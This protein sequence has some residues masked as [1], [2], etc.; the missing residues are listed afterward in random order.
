MLPIVKIPEVVEHFTPH[1]RDLFSKSDYTK[2][3]RYLSGLILSENKTIEGINRHFVVEVQDQ[4]TLNRFLT[5]SN[6][7]YQQLNQRRLDFLQSNSAT[8]FKD[9]GECKGVLGIDD[10]LLQHYGES[11]E[12]ISKL[13]DPH[14]KVI[15]PAHNLIN[16]YYS[17]DQIDYPVYQLLWQP[18]DIAALVDKMKALNIYLNPEKE[19]RREEEPKAWRKYILHGRYKDN[20]YKYPQLVDIY[21]TKLWL[22]RDLVDQQVARYPEL[23]L[24]FV[25]D[26]WFTKPMLCEHIDRLGKAYVGLLESKTYIQSKGGTKLKVADFA[27]QL[28]KQHLAGSHR[29]FNKVGV[30]WRGITTHYYAYT[31]THKLPTFGKVRMVIS[32]R[33][34][35]LS[36]K[37]Y[38]IITNQFKWRAVGILNVYRRRWPVEV[39]HEEGK[40]EGLDQ[41]QIRGF[42]AIYKH[43]A[44]ISLVYSLLHAARYDLNLV[45]KLQQQLQQS[46]DELL[47]GSVAHWRRVVKA[48]S[49]MDLLNWTT[50]NV[51]SAQDW[52]KLI[53]PIV[54]AIAY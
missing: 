13:R 12:Q 35:D 3:Q 21:K 52:K 39:F 4:S 36:D 48:Q 23:D 44:L 27:E 33:K 15:L 18:P 43:I 32:Y 16:L 54:Q 45:S 37:P 29:H 22:A 1:F 17:D 6:F 20:Q 5:A 19:K 46:A 2:F 34:A 8:C 10:T 53:I 14:S 38:I 11:F 40:A 26:R 24:P 28:K 31:K 47:N 49:F 25:F 50:K 7:D 9:R 42:T 41:Y 51:Q 30:K